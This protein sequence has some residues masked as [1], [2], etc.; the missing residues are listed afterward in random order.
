MATHSQQQFGEA[1]LSLAMELADRAGGLEQPGDVPLDAKDFFALHEQELRELVV[2]FDDR[3]RLDEERR[4]GSGSLN[5]R[6][7]LASGCVTSDCQSMAAA[8]L[9]PS[10]TGTVSLPERR[11]TK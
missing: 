6:T 1:E 10:R 4:A 8:A 3:D 7:W 9:A 2:D 5:S 11:R